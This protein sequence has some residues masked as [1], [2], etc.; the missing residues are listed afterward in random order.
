MHSSRAMKSSFRIA[1][2]AARPEGGKTVFFPQDDRPYGLKCAA[3]QTEIALERFTFEKGENARRQHRAA[4]PKVSGKTAFFPRNDRPYGLKCAAF[5]TEIALEQ[6]AER[7]PTSRSASFRH[8]AARKGP[9]RSTPGGQG[10]AN[11]SCRTTSRA[12]PDNGPSA[13]VSAGRDVKDAPNK[14][15]LLLTRKKNGTPQPFK[16]PVTS[17]RS[18]NNSPSSLLSLYTRRKI[19]PSRLPAAKVHGRHG[20]IRHRRQCRHWREGISPCTPCRD[21]TRP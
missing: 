3:F 21:D 2:H 14:K 6:E 8:A 18:K 5:Q 16:L 13:I 12:E 15:S 4:R 9:T 10:A 1:A 19:A 17:R 20:R 7:P 11:V